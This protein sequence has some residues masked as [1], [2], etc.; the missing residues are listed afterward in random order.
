MNYEVVMRIL[1]DESGSLKRLA[2]ISGLD[3][4]SFFRGASLNGLDLSNQDLRG[5]NFED[6]DLRDANLENIEYDAGAFN[7]ANLSGYAQSFRDPFEFYIDDIPIVTFSKIYVYARFRPSSLEACIQST[8]MTYQVFGSL[9]T[10]NLTTLRKARR[11]QVVSIDTAYQIC[12]TLVKAWSQDSDKVQ[13][14]IPLFKEVNSSYR[15]FVQPKQPMIE[16]LDLTG[17]GGFN[18]I[19]RKRFLYFLEGSS[20]MLSSMHKVSNTDIAAVYETVAQVRQAWMEKKVERQ[21]LV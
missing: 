8:G 21:G 16:L 2:E 6:A 5:L 17:G 11:G 3:P 13:Y 9:G 15:S 20:K 12:R 4:F 14:E 10:L 1:F 7:G 19:S 18:S